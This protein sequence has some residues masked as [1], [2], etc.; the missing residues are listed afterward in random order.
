MA[1]LPQL[2]P[3]SGEPAV[4][5]ALQLQLHRPA[6]GVTAIGRTIDATMLH[7]VAAVIE[8]P[9]N[10][11]FSLAVSNVF[12]EEPPLARLPEGYDAMTS[13]PLGR[14]I[15]MG[16]RIVLLGDQPSSNTGVHHARA[17][18]R[19]FLCCRPLTVGEMSVSPRR[20]GDTPAKGGRP[21]AKVRCDFRQG[22]FARMTRVSLR[23]SRDF[24]EGCGRRRRPETRARVGG[25]GASQMPIHLHYRGIKTE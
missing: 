15:R 21:S 9:R 10:V 20:C 11:T 25:G 8:L 18:R 16:L 17:A 22:S 1:G 19:P 13:D 2:R 4:V 6:S 14:T 3:R 24:S 12:D 7:D 5:G 23:Y